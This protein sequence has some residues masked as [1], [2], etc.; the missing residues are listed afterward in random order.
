MERHH[1]PK[2]W[3]KIALAFTGKDVWTVISKYK[4]F[5]HVIKEQSN[6]SQWGIY[7]LNYYQER[8]PVHLFQDAPIGNLPVEISKKKVEWVGFKGWSPARG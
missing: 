7:S 4:H 1:S 2:L 3:N 6:T 8:K 5:K